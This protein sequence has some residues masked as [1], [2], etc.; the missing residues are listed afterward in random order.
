MYILDS[1][2]HAWVEIYMDGYGWIPLEFTPGYNQTENVTDNTE[3][4]FEEKEE[5]TK[6]EHE[7]TYQELE[8]I[9]LERETLY[10]KTDFDSIAEYM[11][12]NLTGRIDFGIV[13][14]ILWKDF[15]KLLK[16]LLYV[17]IVLFVIALGFYIPAVMSERKRKSL[18]VINENN[19][20]KDDDEQIAKLF[21]YVDKVCR[22]LKIK[23]TDDMTC[24]AYVD[25]MKARSE[26]F[27]KAKVENIIYA[28]EKISFGH[29]NI[30]KE[31]MKKAV[32]AAVIIRSDVYNKLSRIEKLLYRFI[33][34]L[35]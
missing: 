16:I 30:G 24:A 4:E 33:W 19:T 29:G 8:S 28:I 35:Y 25:A 34:H 15:L 11:E 18:F 9:A 5:E 22:F 10:F 13:F 7:T 32:E 21:E 20:P 6:K 27:E 23:K 17:A 2:A 26:S 14:S 31:E 3:S 12:H 1:Y